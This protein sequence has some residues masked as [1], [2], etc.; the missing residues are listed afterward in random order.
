MIPIKVE[1]G[2]TTRYALYLIGFTI[3]LAYKI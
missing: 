2:I 3:P 1:Y